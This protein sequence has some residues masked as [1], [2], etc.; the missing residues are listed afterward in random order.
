M[1]AQKIIGGPHMNERLNIGV[2]RPKIDLRRICKMDLSRIQITILAFTENNSGFR[3]RAVLC[4]A[5]S[6]GGGPSALGLS[7]ARFRSLRQGLHRPRQFSTRAFWSSRLCSLL[8]VR[9]AAEAPTPMGHLIFTFR[10]T[11]TRLPV[12]KGHATLGTAVR[13]GQRAAAPIAA[14]LFSVGH[15]SLSLCPLIG[16]LSSDPTF[17]FYSL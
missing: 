14:A 7:P 6:A 1:C 10:P 13:C 12:P 2:G 11:Q 15:G 5:G 4:D 3:L 17:S 9:V 8:P 16:R